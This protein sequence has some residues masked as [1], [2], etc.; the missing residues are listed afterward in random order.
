LVPGNHERSTIPYPLLAR[1]DNLRI[2]RSRVRGSAPAATPL[3]E[4]A[5]GRASG[6]RVHRIDYFELP[7]RP[8]VRLAMRGGPECRE[9]LVRRLE[10]ALERLD[11]EAVVRVVGLPIGTLDTATL[12]SP[13]PATMNVDFDRGDF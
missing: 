8:M 7:S 6:G 4:L 11:P 1:H 2:R 3:V 9:I 10:R 13:A 12:R 5:A